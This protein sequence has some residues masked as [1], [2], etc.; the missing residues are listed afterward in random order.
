MK[1]ALALLITTVV[2]L[3]IIPAL[4][5]TTIPTYAQDLSS[6]PD[7]SGL[8]IYFS[9]ANSE[10]SQFDRGEAGIS[11]FA[12]LLRLMGANTFTLEWRKG[13]PDNTDLIV[14]PNP[15]R[16]LSPDMVARLWAYL[17]NG[18]RVLLVVDAFDGRGTPTRIPVGLFDLLWN[19][20]GLRARTDV[21]VVP[22]ETTDVE[23]IETNDAGE[24]ISQQTVES[25][26]LS[27]AFL[28]SRTSNSH[29]IIDGLTTSNF[30]T[31]ENGNA[32]VNLSRF[33][34]DG[35]RS[36]ELNGALATASIT[37]LLFTDDAGMYGESDYAT[38]L[39]NQIAEYNIGADTPPGDLI[40]AAA[41]EDSSIDS[42]MVL[43]SD[44]DF[45]TNGGGFITS[46]SYSGS[47]VYPLNV[48]FMIRSV[49]WLLERDI[50]N[51]ALPTPGPTATPTITP[52]PTPTFT[53]TPATT[54]GS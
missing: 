54:D 53:P 28:T 20:I 2:L 8:N 13:I 36:V 11:R 35:A 21:V 42:R 23:I 40:L 4:S 49:A 33:V 31:D 46:P 39:A 24:V 50:T 26:T 41:Y 47:F 3:G 25:L 12:A 44:G 9:E 51:I 30:A 18:G 34:F 15:G 6:M 52:S 43:L 10:S 5:S 29:P 38:Y 14:I 22:G 45:M 7:L 19:D 27:H 16:D 32:P 17:Q 48:Q 1:K 37:P